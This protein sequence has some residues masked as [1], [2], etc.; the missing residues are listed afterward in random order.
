MRYFNPKVLLLGQFALAIFLLLPQCASAQSGAVVEAK[1]KGPVV[2]K[3][4]DALGVP[5]EVRVQ[6]GFHINSHQPDDKYLIPLRIHWDSPLV[7]AGETTFPKPSSQTFSLSEKPLSVYE[8]VFTLQQEFRIKPGAT[9]GFGAITG[10]LTYQACTDTECH[11]PT[12]TPLRVTM[13][14][15]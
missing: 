5:V 8:G 14:I 9:R 15:R 13:D 4:G 12:S 10:K 3:R 11:P 1:S 6:K 2:A 7:E